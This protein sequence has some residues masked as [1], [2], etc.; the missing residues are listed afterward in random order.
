MRPARRIRVLGMAAL[1]AISSIFAAGCEVIEGLNAFDSV[2]EAS[3]ASDARA[4]T[5]DASDDGGSALDGAADSALDS[6]LDAPYD[7]AIADSA[8]PDGAPDS[9]SDA[10]IGQCDPDGLVAE[11]SYDLADES[12]WLLS[13]NAWI[14]HGQVVQQD[15]AILTDNSVSEAGAMWWKD[16]VTLFDGFDVSFKLAIAPQGADGMGFGW[17]P[18]AANPGVGQNGDKLG[19]SAVSGFGVAI[20]T[21]AHSQAGDPNPPYFAVLDSAGHH[22]AVSATKSTAYDGSGHYVSITMT[23]GIVTVKYDFIDTVINK[24]ALPNYVPYSGH[25]GFFASTG[26]FSEEHAITGITGRFGCLSH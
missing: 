13:G 17:V 3:D 9:S 4:P 21:Y 1:V 24:F 8:S 2:G 11:Q 10:A 16:T 5:S 23:K 7:G 12:R 6:A 25:W 14:N 15:W 18:G 26:G 20:V 22:L 19:F